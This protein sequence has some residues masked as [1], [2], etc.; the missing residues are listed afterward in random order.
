M[1]GI[2]GE[3]TNEAVGAIAIKVTGC[4]GIVTISTS[5]VGCS[6][7]ATTVAN[8][9]VTAAG[10]VVTT[11]LSVRL[12]HVSANTTVATDGCDGITH[13]TGFTGH[14]GSKAPSRR[15]IVTG[16][17][18]FRTVAGVTNARGHI[19]GAVDVITAES[20]TVVSVTIVTSQ[21]GIQ[22]SG[23]RTGRDRNGIPL[24]AIGI[25]TVAAVTGIDIIPIRGLNVG[26]AIAVTVHR[27]SPVKLVHRC[28]RGQ[29][30]VKDHI[31]ITVDMGPGSDINRICS[32]PGA[33]MAG[34]ASDRQAGQSQVGVMDCGGTAGTGVV[35]A[36]TAGAATRP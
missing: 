2:T 26:G 29:S 21:S 1:T 34:P 12:I 27:T 20:R 30:R 5:L 19:F 18:H 33:V 32:R 9:C 36:G 25:M 22:V 3:T 4:A 11:A 23:V 35:T 7:T 10:L 28:G 16:S 17:G 31:D 14:T 13:V 24:Y 8:T 15:G 6:I